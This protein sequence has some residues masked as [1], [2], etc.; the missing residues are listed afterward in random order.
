MVVSYS[1]QRD[2]PK[3][4]WDAAEEQRDQTQTIII[5]CAVAAGVIILIVLVVIF[6]AVRIII[7]NKG[8]LA[9]NA[10][11]QRLNYGS[12]HKFLGIWCRTWSFLS[13][14]NSSGSMCSA[15]SFFLF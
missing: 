13:H 6:M 7:I 5:I 4:V 10:G 12:L 8:L 11:S 9:K 14:L 2:V 1:S 3:E 15:L